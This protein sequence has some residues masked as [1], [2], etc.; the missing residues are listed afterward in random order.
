MPIVVSPA[1]PGRPGNL[2]TVVAMSTSPPRPG[3]EAFNIPLRVIYQADRIEY[4]ECWAKCDMIYALSTVALDRVYAPWSAPHGGRA[5]LV[6]ELTQEQ[7]LLVRMG[8][9][10]AIGL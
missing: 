8:I 7:L 6:P 4:F 1:L 10:C 9:K 3:T 5:Y 2:V